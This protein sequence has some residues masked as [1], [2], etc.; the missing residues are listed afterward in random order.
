MPMVVPK[1]EADD[2]VELGLSMYAR[3][4]RSVAADHGYGKAYKSHPR[5]QNKKKYYEHRRKPKASYEQQSMLSLELT[6]AIGPVEN[7]S[8]TDHDGPE[9]TSNTKLDL[10]L[11]L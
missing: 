6:L 9:D 11:R 10:T 7:Y 8:A 4:A 1:L 2:R 5:D 3:P